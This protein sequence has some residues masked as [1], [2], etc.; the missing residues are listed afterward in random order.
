MFQNCADVHR[1]NVLRCGSFTSNRPVQTTLRRH[2]LADIRPCQMMMKVQIDPGAVARFNEIG[3]QVMARGE[4]DH[5][6]RRTCLVSAQMFMSPPISPTER[7]PAQFTRCKKSSTKRVHEGRFF[8]SGDH[9][10]VWPARLP[11][12]KE[13]SKEDGAG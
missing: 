5:A 10:V 13:S 6:N 3:E 4:K 9:L 7:P 8:Q 1:L 12:L 2:R 11:L